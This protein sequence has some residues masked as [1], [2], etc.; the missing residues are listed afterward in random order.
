MMDFF[1]PELVDVVMA[2]RLKDA[3][4]VRISRKLRSQ[5]RNGRVRSRLAG[6]LGLV[7]ASLHPE[8]ARA[9]VGLR[10]VP[11]MRECDR[12][13]ECGWTLCLCKD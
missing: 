7:A 4:S 9:A 10:R 3:G 13:A 6:V 11:H 2:E 1:G 5:A 8:A 12:S